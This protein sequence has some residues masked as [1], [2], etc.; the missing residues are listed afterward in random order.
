VFE[1]ELTVG[2]LPASAAVV[3]RQAVRAVARRGTEL[4]LLRSRHG[5]YKFPGGGV[6]LGETDERALRRELLEECGIRDARIGEVLV[7]V[8]ERRPAQTPGSVLV[9]T[10]DYVEVSFPD[11]AVGD[12]SLEEYERELDLSATWVDLE[13]AHRANLAVLDSWSPERVRDELPWL[14]RETRVLAELLAPP[15]GSDDSRSK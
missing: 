9:M 3:D 5:D 6:E 8:T 4:F 1:I 15:G 11:D 2:D 13:T 14:P 7:R 10:S 12:V